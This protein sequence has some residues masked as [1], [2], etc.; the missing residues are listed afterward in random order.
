MYAGCYSGNWRSSRKQNRQSPYAL[1][2]VNEHR[3]PLCDHFLMR[4][5]WRWKYLGCSFWIPVS[6]SNNPNRIFSF[7]LVGASYLF[8]SRNN[9]SKQLS[10]YVKYMRCL[11]VCRS[12]RKEWANKWERD[13]VRKFWNSILVNA[14][15]KMLQSNGEENNL[16]KVNESH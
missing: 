8:V 11:V 14:E 1:T 15:F 3:Q 7:V 9:T 13:Y 16:Q 12:I 4:P 5:T 2:E 10:S 6:L